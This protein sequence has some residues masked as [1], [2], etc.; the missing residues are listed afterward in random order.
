ME[1]DMKRAIINSLTVLNAKKES[2]LTEIEKIERD[3]KFIEDEYVA[4][5]LGNA[6]GAAEGAL[7][8]LVTK[9]RTPS[10]HVVRTLLEATTA[11]EI[12]KAKG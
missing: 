4:N 11:L 8:E 6:L 1:T 3:I 9:D 10:K 5:D 12:A 7:T 2:L